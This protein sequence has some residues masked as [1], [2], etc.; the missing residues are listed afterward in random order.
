MLNFAA[1]DIG[2]LARIDLHTHSTRSDG[3]GSPAQVMQEAKAAGL[4]I[5]AL[6]DHD[7]TAGWAEAAEAC[8]ELGLGFVPGI[9]LTTRAHVIDPETGQERRFATHLLAYLP[10]PYNAE[11]NAV[12]EES[13]SSRVSRLKAI[14]D[15][16]SEDYDIE[17]EHVQEVISDGRTAGRPAIADAMI[18]RGI[19]AKRDQLFE[20]VYPGS[21]YYQP[22]RGVPDTVEAIGLIRRAGGVPVIAHP[23]ARGKAPAPGESMPRQHFVEMI[24]AGLAGFEVD[25]RDVPPHAREWLTQLAFE[26]DLI[27]TGSSDYHGTGKDNVLGENLTAPDVLRRILAQGFAGSAAHSS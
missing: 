17:W 26:F 9:E 18:Q 23:M 21:K 16:L 8:D 24:Q 6:T 12:M 13:L 10:D 7:T 14:T 2:D 11:L 15:A 27:T 3:R 19:F 22:N 20:L 5:V 25:H 4:D 1:A